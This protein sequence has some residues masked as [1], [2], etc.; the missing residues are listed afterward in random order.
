MNE[1]LSR[2]ENE[3]MRAVF[4]LSEEKERFLVYP[5]E[6]SAQIRANRDYDEEKLESVMRTLEMD[7][8]FDF[9]LSERKGE[10]TYVIHMHEAGLAYKRSDIQ[11]RRSVYFRWG[12]AAVGAVITFFIGLV[13][14][15]IFK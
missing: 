9:V 4:E 11:R 13:L 15:I 6:I 2:R 7:G 14:R 5:Y 3:V 1:K 10:K 12:V 8:Y